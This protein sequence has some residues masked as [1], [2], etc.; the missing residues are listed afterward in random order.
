MTS[1]SN[2]RVFLAALIVGGGFLASKITGIL[3]DLLL[4]KMIGA[5]HDLDPY[6]AAFNLPDLLFTLIAGGALAAAFIPIF[7]TYLARE[8]RAGAW[9]LASAVINTA[10][11]AAL[12]ASIAL[13]IL[14]PWIV[15]QT[16][17]V[18]FQPDQQQ[19]TANLMRTILIGTVIFAISG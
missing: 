10:F 8:D 16:V 6:Y 7:S 15:S 2:R 1:T 4:A 9:K 5:G 3:D 14:A 12:V 13:A 18:G 11:L 19:L 17:G